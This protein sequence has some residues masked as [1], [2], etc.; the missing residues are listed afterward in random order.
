MLLNKR[1]ETCFERAAALPIALSCECGKPLHVWGKWGKYVWCR[2]CVFVIDK[3]T[4][5]EADGRVLANPLWI[6]FL[7]NTNSIIR[8][9]VLS[10]KL[11]Q[12]RIAFV[13]TECLCATA[14]RTW[15]Y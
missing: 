3:L 8:L 4:C 9:M 13:V 10:K 15:Q 14:L 2:F 7:D 11:H 6:C 5:H 12:Y 1:C